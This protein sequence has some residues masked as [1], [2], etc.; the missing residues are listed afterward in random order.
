M[1]SLSRRISRPRGR[2]VSRLQRRADRAGIGVSTGRASVVATRC[3]RRRPGDMAR[4]I[5]IH[6]M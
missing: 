1:T 4:H 3:E 2:D 6:L 5:H